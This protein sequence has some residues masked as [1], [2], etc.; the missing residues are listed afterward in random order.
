MGRKTVSY[1]TEDRYP[2]RRGWIYKN[3]NPILFLNH[4]GYYSTQLRPCPCCG[5]YPV[6]E[7]NAY[8]DIESDIAKSF[9]GYCQMC[10]IHTY[11]PGT[12]REAVIMWQGR[13]FSKTSINMNKRP[14]YDSLYGVRSLCNKVVDAAVVDA[15]LY[16]RE[17][18]TANG[19]LFDSYGEQL[20]K[21]EKFFRTSVFMWEM[22]PDG[23][24]SDIRRILYPNMTP[25]DRTRIPNHLSELYKGKE[26]EK[27]IQEE[28]LKKQQLTVDTVPPELPEN[29]P[30]NMTGRR[31][32]KK[33]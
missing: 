8:V 15:I 16:A 13:K 29:T 31:T 12:L 22:D 19:E 9:L 2:Q 14:K 32:R 25:E 23:I 30:R 18:Q 20:D 7:E 4:T 5:R 24:I 1:C 33:T 21:L 27:C 10:E 26:I 6:F 3:S 11:K 17:R 28:N